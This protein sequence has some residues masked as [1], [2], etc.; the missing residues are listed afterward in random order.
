[1]TKQLKEIFRD[2]GL[3][4]VTFTITEKGYNMESGEVKADLGA[5]PEEAESYLRGENIRIRK[6]AADIPDRSWVLV[7]AGG[8]GLGWA[9]KT[10]DLLKNKY[11]Y[12]KA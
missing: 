3:Q 7:T 8:F 6:E 11:L 2:P 4:L 12:R 1:M 9:K 5:S 10:G